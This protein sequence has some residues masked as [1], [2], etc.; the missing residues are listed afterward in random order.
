MQKIRHL[1]KGKSL[2]LKIGII[3]YKFAFCFIFILNFG[4]SQKIILK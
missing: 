3:S 2:I 1:I 4:I